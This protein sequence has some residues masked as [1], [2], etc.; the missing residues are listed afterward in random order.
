VKARGGGAVTIWSNGAT[1]LGRLGVDTDG[2]GQLLSTLRVVTSTGRPV[3]T[4]DLTAIVDRLGAPVRMVPRRVL[5]ER[6][7]EGFPTD[8]IWCNARAVGVVSTQNGVRL[9]FEERIAK[10]QQPLAASTLGARGDY[11]TCAKPAEHAV[12]G[13]GLQ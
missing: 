12:R 4:V 5:L 3:A 13:V 1:V 6:L 8:R 9:E 7:L 11:S 2:A 10:L